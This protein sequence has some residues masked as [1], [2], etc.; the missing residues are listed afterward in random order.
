MKKRLTIAVLLLT[1]TTVGG[2]LLMLNRDESQVLSENLFN[3]EQTGIT[4]S[5]QGLGLREG[6][7]SEDDSETVRTIAQFGTVNDDEPPV[8]ITIRQESRFRIVSNIAGKPTLDIV[9]DNLLS[10]YPDRFSEFELVSSDEIQVDNLPAIE[11][12]FSYVNDNQELQQKFIAVKKN[13]D[14]IVYLTFQ[15]FADNFAQLQEQKFR[16]IVESIDI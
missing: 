15:S 11:I 8:L 4:F 7:G 2:G 6:D 14:E 16:P 10:N 1:I 12:I 3:D 5:Y 9:R 13:D